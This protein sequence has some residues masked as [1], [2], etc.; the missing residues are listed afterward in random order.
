MKTIE[1]FNSQPDNNSKID[2]LD[3]AALLRPVG[4]RVQGTALVAGRISTKYLAPAIG[5][6]KEFELSTTG[7][8]PD[9]A[10][11]HLL[12]SNACL[13]GIRRT[14]RVG[15]GSIIPDLDLGICKELKSYSLYSGQ[16]VV[17][18]ATNPTGHLL[19]LQKI[20]TVYFYYKFFCKSLIDL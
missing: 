7:K 9:E 14:E 20:Y 13:I 15:S 11:N 1:D 5:V 8:G 6:S 3:R 16:P 10:K 4:F 17:I 2:S 12:V 18:R 19:G